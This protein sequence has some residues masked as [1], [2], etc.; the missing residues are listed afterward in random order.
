METS[1]MPAEAP[2]PFSTASAPPAILRSH[3]DLVRW[4]VWTMLAGV[5]LY[6]VYLVLGMFLSYFYVPSVADALSPNAHAT[7]WAAAGAVVGVGVLLATLGLARRMPGGNIRWVVGGV[8]IFVGLLGASAS[9]LI[10]EA[11][12]S[13]ATS[14]A[15]IGVITTGLGLLLPVGLLIFFFGFQTPDALRR[16]P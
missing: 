16:I 13:G 14:L 3:R 12:V 11:Y 2:V 8:L 10:V 9:Q 15:M 6:V 1:Q 5:L 4:G 7:L